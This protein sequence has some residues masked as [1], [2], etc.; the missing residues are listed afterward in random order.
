[1][2]DILKYEIH[3]HIKQ[4]VAECVHKYITCTQI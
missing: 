3:V 2:V 4:H 1:M